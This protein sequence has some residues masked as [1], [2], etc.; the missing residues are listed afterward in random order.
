MQA[1][2]ADVGNIKFDIEI[3]LE[4]QLGVQPLPFPGMDKAGMAIC[5][6]HIR[7]MCNKAAACPF[8]HVSGDRAIV[9][10][11]WLRGLCK[12]GD[13]CEFLHEYDMS[14]MP[15]CFFFSKYGSCS[16]KECPFLHIDPDAKKKDCP[17]YDRGFCRHGPK[18]K[19]RHVRRILCEA[20]LC[21]FCLEGSNCKFAHASFDI[22]MADITNDKNKLAA[23]VCH[24]CGVSGHKAIHCPAPDKRAAG[25][26]STKIPGM[27]THN[28]T[29]DHN[30][31]FTPGGGMPPGKREFIKRN[32][33]E[34][35]CF[36]CGEK[37]HYANKCPR[38]SLAFLHMTGTGVAQPT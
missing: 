6:F 2:V 36:K 1:I 35:T 24:N 10:K 20:Y 14:K 21:G 9:C 30:S 26:I 12:K 31:T 3:A 22:P 33:D 16:N 19:N 7:S 18:C 23:V 38:G 15:E 13:D 8:R 34:V 32:L 29:P 4:Q 17:W 11:H 5:D 25:A 37:G 28:N 27:P